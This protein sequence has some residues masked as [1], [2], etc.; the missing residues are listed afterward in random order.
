MRKHKV[1]FPTFMFYSAFLFSG[2]TRFF[3]NT[4]YNEQLGEKVL[5]LPIYLNKKKGN[6]MFIIANYFFNLIVHY[7]WRY[8]KRQV[9]PGKW[10]VQQSVNCGK[11]TLLVDW[12]K[13]KIALKCSSSLLAALLLSH[14]QFL[15]APIKT[16][17]SVAIKQFKHFTMA[18]AALDLAKYR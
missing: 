11:I 2:K 16:F 5:C 14:F 4:N 8:L 1:I 12:L 13:I 10:C 15:K 17:A 3:L 18:S 9:F 7:V 6:K